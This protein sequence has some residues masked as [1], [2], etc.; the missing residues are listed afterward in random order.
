MLDIDWSAHV[1][2]APSVSAKTSAIDTFE[3]DDEDEDDGGMSDLFTDRGE[4]AAVTQAPAAS[5]ASGFA[6]AGG[7]GPAPLWPDWQRYSAGG[8]VSEVRIERSSA[9]GKRETLGDFPA[10]TSRVQLIDLYG[11]GGYLITPIDQFGNPIHPHQPPITLTVP[12]DHIHLQQRSRVPSGQGQ[13]SGGGYPP[14]QPDSRMFDYLAARDRSSSER[15]AIEAKER[16]TRE[17]RVAE[18]QAELAAAQAGLTDKT[19]NNFTSM[20]NAMFTE[21]TAR[22]NRQSENERMHYEQLAARERAIAHEQTKAQES[23]LSL[24][25]RQ[26]QVVIDQARLDQDRREQ[27]YKEDRDRREARE[28]MD[29]AERERMRAEDRDRER[30]HSAAMTQ[31]M[32]A[33]MEANNPMNAIMA[34]GAMFVPML[35]IADKFGLIEAFKER[36]VTPKEKEEDDASGWSGTV[37]EVVKQFGE[38]AKIAMT[39]PMEDDDDDDEDDEGEADGVW[40]REDGLLQDDSGQ[41]YHPE[42]GDPLT[43]DQAAALLRGVRPAAVVATA[44]APAAPAAP[45]LPDHVI[46]A[47]DAHK[48]AYREVGGPAALAAMQRERRVIEDVPEVANDVEAP[49][50]PVHP[51]DAAR[52]SAKHQKSAR[53]IMRKLVEALARAEARP[54]TW[55]TFVVSA[56]KRDPE[57]MKAYL[58]V[59]GIRRAAVE[60]GGADELVTRFIAALD[61][62]EGPMKEFVKDIPRG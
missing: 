19:L 57:A 7:N 46:A 39:P 11:A 12:V 20:S 35:G 59:T 17:H 28:R 43:L 18:A 1:R 40:T 56:V 29:A 58:S 26:Q 42:S 16:M 62:F 36:F 31:L 30:Q 25:M 4:P 41:L 48:D 5:P 24:L 60:A 27:S 6:V 33:R 47:R 10:N 53:Q 9:L 49:A 3:D 44:A 55:Q 52:V 54:E 50:A 45:P 38:V 23:S 51:A 32:T 37:K 14:A 34:V 8:Q 61:A 13:S 15:E 22:V 2:T 21:H